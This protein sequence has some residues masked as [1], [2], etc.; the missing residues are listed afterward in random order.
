MN[1]ISVTINLK[2]KIKRCMWGVTTVLSFNKYSTYM[3]EI[4][5]VVDKLKYSFKL[6][7]KLLT[8]PLIE[9]NGF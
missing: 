1:K 6:F 3:N 7:R 8:K 5:K 9:R 4:C 2:F